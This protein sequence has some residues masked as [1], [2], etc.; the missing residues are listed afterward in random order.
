MKLTF[1]LAAPLFSPPNTCN[2][3]NVYPNNPAH[4]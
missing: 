3:G 4:C 1:N 2:T